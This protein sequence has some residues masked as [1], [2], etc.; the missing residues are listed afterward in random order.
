MRL[1]SVQADNPPLGRATRTRKQHTEKAGAG[2]MNSPLPLPFALAK[3]TNAQRVR[4]VADRRGAGGA[5]QRFGVA[6]GFQ[7]DAFWKHAKASTDL[8]E[9]FQSAV[10]HLKGAGA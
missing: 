7:G 4:S 3:I 1:I 6:K 5:D 8:R 2:S 9:Q 10:I